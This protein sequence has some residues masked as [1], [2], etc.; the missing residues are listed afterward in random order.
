MDA[1]EALLTAIRENGGTVVIAISLL[2]VLVVALV[3]MA[4][5]K[6]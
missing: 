3:A 1:T 5:S 2:V 6:R 4:L